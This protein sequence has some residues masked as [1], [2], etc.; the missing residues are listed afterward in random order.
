MTDA[1][2]GSIAPFMPN[3]NKVGKIM[4][5]LIL[6]LTVS[7]SAYHL[8]GA[9]SVLPELIIHRSIHL[10][11]AVPL[12]FLIYPL[13]SG[14]KKG[15]PPRLWDLLQAVLAALPWVWIL[16]NF[17]RLVERMEYVD[18]LST[19]DYAM[20]V[21]AIITVLEATR[22]TVGMAM[23]VLALLVFAY[24]MF[25]EYAPGVLAIKS[26]RLDMVLEHL[27]VLPEG[28]LG[29]P[30]GVT[31]TY[32]FLFV[33][34]GAFL[35]KSGAGDFFMDF[36]KSIAGRQRGGP[37]KVAVVSSA[38]FGTLSGS[39]VANVY[40]TG[41]FT[42]PLM[43][44]IGYRPAFAGAVEA[45]AST[46]G[47][48]MPPIMGSAAFLMADFLGV[49]YLD[50][51]FAAII[52]S[53]LYYVTL[54][55][56][57]DM[58]AARTGMVGLDASEL[59]RPW[60]TLKGGLI[61]LIPLVLI[62]VMLVY[63][64]SP[65]MAAFYGIVVT[66]VL[67]WLKPVS[68]IGL[69]KLS[70]ALDSGARNILPL[71]AACAT[72]GIIIGLISLNGIGLKF[73][74]AVIHLTGGSLFL[75]LILV[76]IA[77]LILGMGL[78]TPAAYILVAI[79]GAPALVELGLPPLAAHMFCFFYAILSSITPPVAMAAYGGAQ[80]AEAGFNETALIALRLG[81]IAFIVPFIF[82]FDPALLLIGGTSKVVLGVITALAG[83][84]LV[85]VSISGWLY[86]KA[87]VPIRILAG[88]GG[89]MML[90]PG[91]RTDVPGGIC[92][93]IVLGIYIKRRLWA[94]VAP[95]KSETFC[96]AES[97]DQRER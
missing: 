72:A 9:A 49:P 32:V 70:Q 14:A 48:L 77:A 67:S 36:A 6:V 81:L 80:L 39:S 85:A 71:S 95:K 65:F 24:T 45:V 51:M 41:I 27:F 34:F 75:G 38:F 83:S 37:G 47:Q 35:E 3:V 17:E 68:R 16:L 22:R 25:G 44:R 91:W 20:A 96:S 53:L 31:A 1:K 84:L 61:N 30:I 7:M 97:A 40:T 69:K 10:I 55:F 76:M 73:T 87:S 52:P 33:L 50:I 82:A 18:P 4:T 15:E 66:F 63:R 90:V 57:L 58:E 46:G 78:P 92:L 62:V 23:V 12:I 59:P 54:Y 56:L 19:M 89:L 94:R 79:F 26:T 93:A 74:A 21:L 43:K 2:R 11:F 86:G 88:A 60:A 64:Y 8:Y 29:M 42:I 13:V 5:N 28:I